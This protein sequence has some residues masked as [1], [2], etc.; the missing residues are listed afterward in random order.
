MCICRKEPAVERPEKLVKKMPSPGHCYE[1]SF[2]FMIEH[3]LGTKATLVH[4]TVRNVIMDQ[5]KR[6]D[7]AWV[8]VGEAV[9]DNAYFD[10]FVPRDA[11][12]RMSDAIVEKRYTQQQAIKTALKHGHYGYWHKDAPIKTR[13]KRKVTVGGNKN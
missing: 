3:P 13:G 7:H 11:Y 2:E 5:K 6:I 4:G 10:Q 9:W 12:Y 1:V 8:E